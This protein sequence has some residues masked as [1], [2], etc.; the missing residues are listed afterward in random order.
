MLSR[1]SFLLL[2]CMAFMLVSVVYMK[3]YVEVGRCRS[4]PCS[5]PCTKFG[6]SSKD[7]IDCIN[8]KCTPSG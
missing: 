4:G 7:C 1:T 3:E 6:V 5:D 8:S 2:L